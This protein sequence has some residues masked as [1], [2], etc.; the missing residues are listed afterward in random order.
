MRC[1][2][3]SYAWADKCSVKEWVAPGFI[4]AVYQNG[5]RLTMHSLN[6]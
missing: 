4:N 6:L 5:L 1:N 2:G 3:M